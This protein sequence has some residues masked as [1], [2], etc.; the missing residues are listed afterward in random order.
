[1]DRALGR[2]PEQR[3]LDAAVLV[4]QGDFQMKHGLAVALEAEMA[5]L[6][7]AGVDRADRDFV[8]LFTANAVEVG[9][10]DLRRLVAVRCRR[11]ERRLEADRLQP[12]VSLRDDAELFGDFPL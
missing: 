9:Y 1:M 6:D 8:D 2:A 4:A 11:P 5:R 10:A 3:L 7:D 12:R